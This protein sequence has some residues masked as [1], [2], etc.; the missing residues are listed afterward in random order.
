[1]I[2]NV[3]PPGTCLI[4]K[5]RKRLPVGM[6][7]AAAGGLTRSLVDGKVLDLVAGFQ[8]NLGDHLAA[9][10]AHAAAKLAALPEHERIRIRPDE[11]SGSPVFAYIRVNINGLVA[12]RDSSAIGSLLSPCRDQGLEGIMANPAVFLDASDPATLKQQL[13]HAH[14]RHPFIRAFLP[15]TN[16][17]SQMSKILL[18]IMRCTGNATTPR[19]PSHLRGHVAVTCSITNP[20]QTVEAGEDGLL[21]NLLWLVDDGGHCPNRMRGFWSWR[22]S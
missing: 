15:N 12:A 17:A 2:A 18:A 14:R 6:S 19:V 10:G 9:A 11:P 22:P 1:L 16:H 5:D 8:T 3:H 20:R 13:P 7:F 21:A 4:T